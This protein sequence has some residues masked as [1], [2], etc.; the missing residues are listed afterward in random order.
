MLIGYEFVESCWMESPYWNIID[1]I[2]DNVES[3]TELFFATSSKL[4]EQ[5][6]NMFIM[7]LW[8]I[9]NSKNAKFWE[10]KN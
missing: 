1:N 4:V 6:F 2:S 8:S 5:A 3:F 9:W 10:E 7:A